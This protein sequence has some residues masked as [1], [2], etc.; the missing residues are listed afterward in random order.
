[1][2]AQSS[3]HF[4]IE[5]AKERLN[6]IDA[7]LASLE[8]ETGKVQA[9]SRARADRLIAELRQRR[10]EFQE[11]VKALGERGEAAQLRAKA[12]LDAEWNRFETD[13]KTFVETFSGQVEQQKATF[14]GRAAALSLGC[15]R[16]RRDLEREDAVQAELTRELKSLQDEVS[17]SQRERAP[18]PADPPTALDTAAPL[19][20]SAEERNLREQLG[21][22]VGE[23][24]R[25]FDE[26]ERNISAHPAASVAGALIIG[27]LIGRMLGRR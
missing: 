24:T 18:H 19:S 16:T 5:Q 20:E 25:L 6:E 17:A 23:V 7:T 9:A 21:D 8:S 4:H 13:V 22:L 2:T 3:M 11:A 14:Q 26:A 15:Q 27:I 10:G 1:M 12:Q